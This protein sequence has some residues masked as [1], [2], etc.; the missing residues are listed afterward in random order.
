LNLGTGSFKSRTLWRGG[1]L[2]GVFADSDSI[3]PSLQMEYFQ[4]AQHELRVKAQ[5]LAIRG[6]NATAYRLQ[7]NERLQRSDADVVPDFAINS[8]GFQV[9]YR[10]KINQ[11][12]DLFLVYSRG[13]ESER[14]RGDDGLAELLSDSLELRDA[15]QFLLKLRYGF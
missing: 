12:S 15:D 5:W 8:F 13:G 14:E 4:G 2:F 9:R 6:R 3:E 11:E 1:T 7:A 10:Y